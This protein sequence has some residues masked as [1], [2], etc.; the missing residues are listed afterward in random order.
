MDASKNGKLTQKPTVTP[1][2]PLPLVPPEEQ[3]KYAPCDYSAA[4]VK[5]PCLEKDGSVTFNCDDERFLTSKFAAGC[6]GSN[7]PSKN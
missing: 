4:N 3:A 7:V 5:V 1:P 2:F 6:I